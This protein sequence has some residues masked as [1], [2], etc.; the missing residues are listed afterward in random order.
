[1]NASATKLSSLSILG[2]PSA[3]N[4]YG[5]R[6]R[7][8]FQPPA[9]PWSRERCVD[10]IDQGDIA[11]VAPRTTG[12]VADEAEPDAGIRVGETEDGAVTVEAE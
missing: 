5:T 10:G 8:F 2:F 12:A 1:M 7:L 4:G 11:R 6:L 9:E 3:A